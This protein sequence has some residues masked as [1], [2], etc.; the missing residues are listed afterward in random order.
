MGAWPCWPQ[1]KFNEIIEVLLNSRRLDIF[2]ANCLSTP[3]IFAPLFVQPRWI[4]RAP[5][6]EAQCALGGICRGTNG[7]NAFSP[8]VAEKKSDYD[9]TTKCWNPHIASLSGGFWMR[10]NWERQAASDPAVLLCI[11]STRFRFLL[12]QPLLPAASLS[13]WSRQRVKALRQYNSFQEP[14]FLRQLN[15]W[16]INLI[17]TWQKLSI[18]QLG[19]IMFNL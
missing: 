13:C 18:C 16:G 12:G 10:M 17:F 3:P 14:T 8:N 1:K 5:C 4:S 9:Y 11:Q 15:L 7:M 19:S 6:G 2:H